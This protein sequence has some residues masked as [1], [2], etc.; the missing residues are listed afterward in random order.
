MG[1]FCFR[2][3]RVVIAMLCS[4]V[5][6]MC[7][8]ERV[9]VR[10]VLCCVFIAISFSL[11]LLTPPHPCFGDNYA[12]GCVFP[13][14]LSVSHSPS[15]GKPFFLQAACQ[16]HLPIVHRSVS[17][18]VFRAI[19]SPLSVRRLSAMLHA[20]VVSL[21]LLNSPLSSQTVRHATR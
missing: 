8:R 21:S 6:P 9:Y 19:N 14:A 13:N 17:L 4:L 20:G 18:A 10:I 5:P 11:S 3:R 1:F 2:L 12:M 7:V 16:A 15:Q